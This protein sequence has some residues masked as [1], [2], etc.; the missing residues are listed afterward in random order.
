MAA[1]EDGDQDPI[2]P[3]GYE[4]AYEVVERRLRGRIERGEFAWHTPIPSEPALAEWYGVSRTTVRSAIERLM[5]KGMVERR[6]GKGTY[7][8]W[9]P[10]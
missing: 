6:P 1:E 8:T 3:R 9:R 4:L 7:V 5:A 2:D 10:E